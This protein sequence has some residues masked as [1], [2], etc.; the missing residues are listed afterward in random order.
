MVILMDNV[1][2]NIFGRKPLI[3]V[4]D[5]VQKNLQVVGTT[6]MDEGYEISMANH[7]DKA[8]KLLEKIT[9][10]L[11]LLD[12]MMPDINGYQVCERIKK[13]VQLRSIPII[14]LTAKAELDDIVNGF[15]LGAVDYITKPF[16]KEELLIRIKTHLEVKFSREIIEH[17]AREIADYNLQLKSI[18]SELEQSN[19]QK[20]ELLALLRSELDKASEYVQSLLP[21]P[22]TNGILRTCWKF[23]PSA[24]LSGDSFGYH[25]IDDD[26]FA[27]YL[28]D[29]CGHGIGSALLSVSA[30]NVIK[31]Q[32]L[33]DCDFRLP[34]QVM[35]SLNRSFQMIDHNDSYFTLWYGV[36]NKNTRIIKHSSAGHHEALVVKSNGDTDMLL[37]NNILIGL[38]PDTQY[39][40]SE[41]KL[42]GQANLYIF[43]DGAFE[44]TQESDIMW[45]KEE[46]IDLLST[47]PFDS[48]DELN[49]LL[50]HIRKL[51]GSDNL[52][53]DFSMMKIK[54]LE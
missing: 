53:D 8:L 52:D 43:T 22:I 41:Y 5:D 48:N 27:M 12:V 9:P 40:S 13:N 42:E 26:N 46:F 31:F 51:H 33:P 23:V 30:L 14:F 29:V 50:E 37:H 45:T 20:Q 25:W 1:I 3:L 39:F 18:N 34:E 7:G 10:D 38:D 49:I 24:E 4:V 44:I 21:K 36:Y 47:L 15:R 17:N 11:I 16:K 28:L 6:L 32:T 35:N 19:R 2:Q 54:F